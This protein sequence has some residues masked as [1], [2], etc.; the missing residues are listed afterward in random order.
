[1][2]RTEQSAGALESLYILILSLDSFTKE[3]SED[4]KTV[5]EGATLL[6]EVKRERGA[7]RDVHV[8]WRLTWS[9]GIVNASSQISPMNGSLAFKQVFNCEFVGVLRYVFFL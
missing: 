8:T 9:S 4:I 1:M 7:F 2:Y 3:I 6:L 5:Q